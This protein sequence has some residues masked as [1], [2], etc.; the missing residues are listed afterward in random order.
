[1]RQPNGF[2]LLYSFVRLAG[3]PFRYRAVGLEHVAG[4]GPAIF[5]ANHMGAAGPLASVLSLPIRL[6]PWAIAEM[7]DY[8]RATRYLYEDFVRPTWHLNGAAG[9]AVSF[10]VSRLSVTLLRGIG[11]ISVERHR[12]ESFGAFRRSLELLSQGRNLLVFPEDAQQPADPATRLYPW[13]CG[14]V[15][16]CSMHERESGQRLPLYPVAV[17]PGTKTLAVGEAQY[18]AGD[19]SH[20]LEVRRTCERLRQAVADL[21]VALEGGTS[22]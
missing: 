8:R 13:L 3:S 18:H 11:S 9:L 16:L 22:A 6:Y 7:T 20:R 21:Y 15:G 5:V 1:M 17:H 12:G 19:S 14:F 2:N 10:L 4:P